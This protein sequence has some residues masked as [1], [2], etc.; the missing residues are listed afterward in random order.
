M[1]DVLNSILTF[2]RVR[3]TIPGWYCKCK[4]GARTVGC[5]AHIC[6]VIWYL[7]YGR[8]NRYKTPQNP[9]TQYKKYLMNAS[10]KFNKETSDSDENND[11]DSDD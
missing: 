3:G 2:F 9:V 8:V 1:A 6:S 4:C 7:G 5:C 11:T 10:A